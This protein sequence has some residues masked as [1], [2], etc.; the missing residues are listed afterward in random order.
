MKRVNLQFTVFFLSSI[1][2]ILFQVQV[3]AAFTRICPLNNAPVPLEYDEATGTFSLMESSSTEEEVGGGNTTNDEEVRL[4]KRA[5]MRTVQVAG[6]EHKRYLR[7]RREEAKRVYMARSCPC[8]GNDETNYC[9]VEGLEGSVHDTCGI[10]HSALTWF[11][12][13][14]TTST[15]KV[16]CFKLESHTV[17]IRNAWPVIVFWY[18]ALTVFLV[19]TD[20]GKN[21]RNYVVSKICPSC[22]INERRLDR[23]MQR[24]IEHRERILAATARFARLADGRGRY[25]LRTRGMRIPNDGP[26]VIGDEAMGRWI[27]Q[28]E[29]LGILQT[30]PR[31]TEYVLQTR[32]FNAKHELMRREQT[33]L[34]K[35]NECLGDGNDE[36]DDVT[37]HPSTP[38]KKGIRQDIVSTPETIASCDDDIEEDSES[39]ED[40]VSSKNSQTF[41]SENN[42]VETGTLDDE[43]EDAPEEDAS[44]EDESFDCTICLAPVEDGEKVGVLP[45]SHIFHAE[46][47]GHWIQR[48]NVCPLCQA[49]EIA[50]PRAIDEIENDASGEDAVEVGENVSA[51]AGRAADV[52]NMQSSSPPG[53][54]RTSRS[55]RQRLQL[56]SQSH[57]RRRRRNDDFFIYS[58]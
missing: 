29:S 45:C 31:P 8:G 40:D 51:S 11:S 26:T 3:A 19:A 23:I 37:L 14:N 28:A 47:L 38:T 27:A 34:H 49:S 35:A 36:G 2:F 41:T 15:T 24:E 39:E 4:L 42:E 53:T 54:N 46:C 17:F 21:V 7:A 57:Q 52:S 30:P 50:S 10:T 22:R 6:S 5:A 16:E 44:G 12:N 32:K 25:L 20:N 56:Q 9:L 55:Q 43:K 1:H 48:R 18:L 13:N 33:R 58:P